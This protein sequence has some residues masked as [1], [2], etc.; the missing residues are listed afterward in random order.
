[1]PRTGNDYTWCNITIVSDIPLFKIINLK[2]I[3]EQTSNAG[4]S[5]AIDSV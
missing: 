5:M 4:A 1:M 2:Q 3:P